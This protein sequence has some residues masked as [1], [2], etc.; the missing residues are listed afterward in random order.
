[1]PVKGSE[2]LDF[3]F[4]WKVS[5][6]RK[7]HNGKGICGKTLC[8]NNW[9]FM[10]CYNYWKKDDQ[11]ASH[12]LVGICFNMPTII[13]V[14]KIKSYLTN[15]YPTKHTWKFSFNW[16]NVYCTL[17]YFFNFFDW[18]SGFQTALLLQQ[19]SVLVE[20]CI[21]LFHPLLFSFRTTTGQTDSYKDF[22]VFL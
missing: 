12:R 9:V 20:S 7:K 14:G 17:W 5:W 6:N 3:L 11:N 19:T 8:S 10:F 18:H 21:C 4:S 2:I 16:N 13:C 15:R 1:M 22:L